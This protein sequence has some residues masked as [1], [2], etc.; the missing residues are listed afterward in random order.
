MDHDSAA[1][2]GL[3]SLALINSLVFIIF[4]FSFAKPRSSRDWRSFGAFPAFLVALF[5]EMYG[6]PLTIYLFGRCYIRR[7]A[8]TGLRP[9]ELTRAC[10]IPSTRGSF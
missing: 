2:Y 9:A 6:F 1:A 7:S 8:S 5:T 4:A 3:W 10:G